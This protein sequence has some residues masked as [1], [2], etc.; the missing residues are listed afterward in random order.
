MFTSLRA[1][2]LAW[3][4]T[5]LALV[6]VLV[7]TAVC[8][9]AWRSRLV[10][11]DASLTARAEAL[12][13][14]VRPAPGGTF[15]LTL[16]S[17]GAAVRTDNRPAVYHILWT[18][19]GP[20]DR[21]D[22]ERPVP[23]PSGPGA[24]TR[25]GSR[26]ITIRSAAGPLVLVGSELDRQRDDIRA[27]AGLIAAVGAAALA[28]AF[29]GGWLLVGRALSPIDRISR[30]A[31]RMTEGDFAARIP[32]HRVETELGQVAH[33]LNDAFDRLH[34]SL[35]R[36]RRFTADASHELRTPLAT[37]ST[38]TQWALARDR[39]TEAYR[40]SL[41]ACQ[42]ATRRMQAVVERLLA[43]ARDQ[44]STAEADRK[45][46]VRLDTLVAGIVRELGTLAADRG[47]RLTIDLPAPVTVVGD[48]GRLLEA[49]TNVVA[50]AIQYNVEG[51]DVRIAL[52]PEAHGTSVLRV[53]DT[54]VGIPLD[55]LPRVFEPFFRADP[56]RSRAAGGAGLGLA[57]AHS[58]VV[59]HGGRI[60]C[61][62]AP[63]RG[64]DIRIELPAVHGAVRAEDREYEETPRVP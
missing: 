12:A 30:T 54:G 34:A 13:A 41:A 38:E 33:A 31:R 40:E 44:S 42:R 63:G 8:Y 37:I 48:P 39:T 51:G 11:V 36:Q 3:Y 14:A 6:I 24:R 5:V 55:A 52:A 49:V 35:E 10:D 57:V 53:S 1:R 64:T 16:P 21:S 9:L 43:L 15:D 19:Q 28:L 56:A 7:G 61:T 45:E 4:T 29:A 20:I 2:L 26:E 17:D 62:S 32:I 22:P 18:P 58:I 59:R 25:E 23:L 46:A 47:I 50:N 27:L 60:S